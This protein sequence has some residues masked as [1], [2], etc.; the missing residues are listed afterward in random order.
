MN[1]TKCNIA[2]IRGDGIG[3]DVTDAALAVIEAAR[4]RTGGFRLDCDDLD[5]GAGYFKETGQDIAP[6]A[7]DACDKAR[8][9]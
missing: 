9:I 8:L 4:G 3:V 1:E 7:E 6:G 5:A 2:V